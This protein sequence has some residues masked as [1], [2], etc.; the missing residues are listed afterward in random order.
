MCRKGNGCTQEVSNNADFWK[1]GAK[2][3]HRTK[4]ETATAAAVRNSRAKAVAR[5]MFF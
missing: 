2:I 4:Y 3:Y 5:Q 1:A